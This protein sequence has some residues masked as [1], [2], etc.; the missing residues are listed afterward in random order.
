MNAFTLSSSYDKT[1]NDQ[2]INKINIRMKEKFNS[3][4]GMKLQQFE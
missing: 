1:Y 3:K 2:L 4:M